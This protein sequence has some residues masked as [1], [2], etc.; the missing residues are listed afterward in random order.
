[1]VDRSLETLAADR[2]ITICFTELDGIDGLWLP[3]ER[4]ILVSNRLNDRRAAEV[5]EHELTHVDIEDGHA[6]LDAAVRRK[7]GRTRVAAIS[8]AA[9][10]LVLLFGIRIPFS[11]GS[12]GDPH[13]QPPPQAGLTTAPPQTAQPPAGSP[14]AEPATRVVTQVYDGGVRTRTV[15]VTPTA[16]PTTPERS[17]TATVGSV[18]PTRPAGP[19]NT[20]TPTVTAPPPTSSAPPSPTDTPT[21]T[22]SPTVPATGAQLP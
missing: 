14:S 22:A 10:S 4:T 8:T 5:L 13:Q 3:E 21:P 2:G 19:M 20:P 16:P 11:G 17:A 9:A 12:G 7:A 18:P 6:A 1:M 15:S